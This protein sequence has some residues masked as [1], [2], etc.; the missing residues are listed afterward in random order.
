MAPSR[1]KVFISYNRADRDWAEWIAGVI[2]RGGYQPII[3][4]WHFRPG[5]DFV[6]KIQRAATE[7]DMTIAVLSEAYLKAEFSQPEWTAAFAEDPTGEK[8]RHIPIRVAEC[9][10]TEI[11]VPRIDIDLVGL[12]ERDAERLVLDGLSPSGKPA[13]PPPLP[14]E[15]AECAIPT[16]PFP[17]NLARLHGVP[18]LPSHYLPRE[19]VLAGLKQKLFASGA[20]VG[21]TGQSSAVGV[22]GMG[23][24]G[25][26][27]LAAALAHD[28]E[29]RQ[30]FSDGIYWL[31]IGQKP[32]LLDLQNRLLS[33]L[34]G[35]E[36]TFPTEQEAKEALR[37]ALQGRPVLIV[38]DDAWTLDA[39]QAF[40]VT[41]PPSRLLITT[42][43]NE[44]L[45]GLGA[46]EDRVAVLSPSDSLEMLAEWSGQKNASDLPPEAAEVAKEC[47]YLPLALAMIGAMVCLRPTAWEDAFS[48]LRH[49][50][51]VNRNFPGYP[52]PNLRRAIELSVEGL[53]SADRERYLNLAVFPEDQPIPEEALRVFW[54]LDEV[55]TRD[56]M[57]RLVARSLATWAPSDTS[58][59]LHDLQ[60]DWIR[61]RREKNLP[62]L[63]LRLVDAW[64][65]LPKLDS[66]AWQRA[67]YHLVQAGRK[68]DLRRLL[69]NFNYLETK[70]T[71]TGANALIAD[72]NYLPEDKELQLVQSTLRLSANVIA[73]DPRQLAGQLTGR[74]LGNTSPEIQVLLRQTAER[75]GWPWLRPLRRSLTAPNGPLIGMLEGHT[76]RV[77]SVVVTPDDRYAVSSSADQTLRV[78]DLATG[79]TKTTLQGHTARVSAV[80]LTPGGRLAVSRSW[81]H[82]LRVWDV[83][84]GQTKSTLQGHTSRVWAVAVTPDGRYV[85]SGSADHTVRVWDL[86]T[87]QTKSTL[88]GHTSSVR[89]LAVTPDGRQV[90]SGSWDN[91]LRVWD[92]A[93]GQ[94][95]MTLQGHTSWVTAVVVTPDGRHVVS[96]SA[97]H[98]VRVWDLAT[99]QTKTTLQG[100]TNAVVLTPDSRDVVSGSAGHTLR[101]WDL[102]TGQTKTTLQ[103]HTS[104]VTAVIITPDGRHVVSG[105]ADHTLRVWDLKDG[106]EVLMFTVDGEV[107]ACAAAQDK[108]T[109]VAGDDFGGLHFLRIVEADETKPAIGDTKIWLLQQ[110]EPS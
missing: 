45:V 98:T 9:S 92:L 66:Y 77:T 69:L 8:R 25:K 48:R 43:N 61:V 82:T 101:V 84:T 52:Y 14:G 67:A 27:V 93:T 46:E 68:H 34:T 100:H 96:G 6:L 97:D 28:S 10:L 76:S 58:L 74:L 95:K 22:Q 49:A 91:T 80:V 79:Q 31:T 53:E 42:R 29:T 110:N 32:R 1:C 18:D 39:A 90:V 19:E 50:D 107:S 38:V 20:D 4:A 65:G 3:Q 73:R 88:Q 47:G 63:H 55:D 11:P 105:S 7:S 64:D 24:I 57:M 17:P 99:G 62:A 70:L 26:S 81:D 5:E 71:A 94:T 16:T 102:V 21:I 106:K 15:R 72:Y 87:G 85:I 36:E 44:V 33:Q 56:C 104:W 59:I 109:I 13:Q 108:R 30:V 89:V 78:W 23:G 75:K 35:S 103:G 12:N 37:E 54:N 83:A 60:G 51:L 40:P 2:D 86:A 41:E